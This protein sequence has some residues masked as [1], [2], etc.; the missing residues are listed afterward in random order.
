MCQGNSRKLSLKTRLLNKLRF[1]LVD[2]IFER[3]VACSIRNGSILS[4]FLKRLIPNNY[5]YFKHSIR[6]FEHN[7]IVLNVDISDYIGHTVFFGLNT[8]LQKLFDL[9]RSDG[10]VFDIGVNIGWTA[11]NMSKICSSGQ[12]YGFEPDSNNFIACSKNL[13]LNPNIHNLFISKVALGDQDAMVKMVISEPTNLGG[14]RVGETSINA[15][16]ADVAM[17]TLDSFFANHS[18]AR[19]DLVK[20]DTEGYELRIL[21]GG[22]TTLSSFHPVLFVEVNDSNLRRNGDSARSLIEFLH[23]IGYINIVDSETGKAIQ[24]EDDI[25]E[26]HMDIIARA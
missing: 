26:I 18:L 20:I 4:P 22:V 8:D 23:E 17:T 25:S 19:L 7:E 10:I 15:G 12:V 1:F 9:C 13:E 2:T 21:Q 14:N 24:L 6:R 16:D 11:M 3:L 5:Q